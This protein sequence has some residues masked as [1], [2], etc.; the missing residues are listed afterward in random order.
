MLEV[1]CPTCRRLLHVVETAT[2]RDSQCPACATVFRPDEHPP[3]RQPL[4]SLSAV[5][6]V[7]AVHS[8]SDDPERDPTSAAAH[9][10]TEGQSRGRRPAR[11][12]NWRVVFIALWL[13]LT[14]LVFL[15]LT[16]GLQD[17]AALVAGAGGRWH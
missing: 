6:R 1:T 3:G 8:R 2:D 11:E 17:V 16:D 7:R 13:G 4:P 10:P 15:G 9:T 12:P 14:L 5:A